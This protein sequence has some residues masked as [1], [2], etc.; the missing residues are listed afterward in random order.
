[1]ELVRS[2]ELIDGIACTTIEQ[3]RPKPHSL[4]G[5]AVDNRAADRLKSFTATLRT[6]AIFGWLTSFLA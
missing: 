1:L 6:A 5:A 2:A 3:T 4:L